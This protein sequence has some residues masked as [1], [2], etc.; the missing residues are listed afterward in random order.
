MCGPSTGLGASQR[1]LHLGNQRPQILHAIRLRVNDD[2]PEAQRADIVLVFQL[3]IHS[4]Q[5]VELPAARRSSSP[6]LTPA[7]AR[8]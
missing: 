1:S 4:H 6:F 8:P 7:D 5:R 3:A 2:Q